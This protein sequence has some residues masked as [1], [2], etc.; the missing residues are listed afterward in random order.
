MRLSARSILL[1]ACA[2]LL[3]AGPGS[4]TALAAGTP[5]SSKITPARKPVIA[6]RRAAPSRPADDA[7][8]RKALK[9]VVARYRS[10]TSYRLEGQ[11]T[12]DAGNSEASNVTTTSLQFTVQRPGRF[13][14][15]V[16]S[17]EMDTRMISDGDTLWTVIPA[18]GQFQAQGMAAL[19]T[20]ADSMAMARQFDPAGEYA[21]LL[22]GVT[23][24]RSLGRDTVHTARGTVTCERYSLTA[25]NAE[26][27]AQGVTLSPRAVWVDPVTHMV[28]M[29]S[30][31]IEQQNAQLGRVHSINVTRMVVA[32]ADPELASTLF[33]YENA[34]GLRRVRRFMRSSPEHSAMEGQPAFDFTLEP[35]GDGPPVKLSALKGK[36]VVLDFWATWCGPCRGWLP[37]V[38][39]ARHDLASKG[40]VVYAVNEREDATKV[41]NYLDKQ[42]LEVPVLMDLSGSVGQ[43]YRA[44]SIPLTVVVGRDGNIFRVM[45]GLHQEDDLRDVLHEAGID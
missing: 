20:S 7:V 9:A 27:V 30:I 11:A 38:A 1:T 45:L 19:R 10:L 32:D 39:K 4:L 31:R 35:L 21:R 18:L 34:D 14:S 40:L 17:T 43:Q 26:A 3:F 15:R 16:Q 23:A 44:T 5:A 6:A 13:S 25:P 37:I 24:V 12:S 36:V 33:C 41:R 22:D 8:A 2:A 28:Y 42:K 29:D